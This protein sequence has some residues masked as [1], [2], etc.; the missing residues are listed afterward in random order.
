MSTQSTAKAFAEVIES[1]LTHVTAQCWQWDTMPTFGSLVAIPGNTF[2]LI[3]IV[4]SIETGSMD[5]MRY[6]F[7]YQKT[8]EELKREHPQIF[9][10]LKTIFTVTLIGYQSDAGACL[11]ATPPVPSKIH[12]FVYPLETENFQAFFAKSDFLPLLFAAPETP[13][14]V[15]ELFLALMN[16]LAQQGMLTPERFEEYYHTFSLLTGNDYRRLKLLMQRVTTQH[17]QALVRPN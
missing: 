11:Y 10:F 14:L 9:D 15:D 13:H 2:T 12:S 1:K 16:E 8:E 3:G 7:P 6:P 5:P 4:S 17:A